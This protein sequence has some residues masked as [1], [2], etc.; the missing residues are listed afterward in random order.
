MRPMPA[1]LAARTRRPSTDHPLRGVADRPMS[2]LVR[3]AAAVVLA[4]AAILS[5]PAPIPVTAAANAAFPDLPAGFA[6]VQLAHG[7]KKPTA[8]V[9]APNG[10]I[11]IAEQFIGIVL[12]R[13]GSVLSTPVLSLTVDQGT[14][15]GILGLALDPNFSTNGYIYV[16]YSTADLHAQVSRFTVTGGGTTASPASEKV[17]V[18]GDELQSAHHGVND[19]H[20]G[21]DGKLWIGMGDN[22]PSISNGHTLNNIYGKILRINLDGTI[23]ADNPFVNVSGA[24]P[25]IYAYGLRNPFRF[26]FLP[27]GKAMT[28]DTGSSYWEELDTI[29]RGGNYGWDYYEGNCFTCGYINPTYAYGH[30]PTDSATSALAAYTGSVFPSTYSDTVF[31]GDY[32]RQDIEAVKFDPTYTTEISQTVFDSAAGTVADLQEGPDGNLYYVGIYEG[33][34]WEI[35]P[36]GPF[37]PTANATSTPTAGQAPLTVQF[38]SAGSSDPT[39]AALGYSW[40]FGDGSAPSTAANPSHTYTTNGTYTADAD[41]GEFGRHRERDDR[42]SEW[43]WRLRLPPSRRRRRAPTTPARPSRSPA[44]RPTRRTARCLPAPT[45]GRSTSTRAASPSPSTSTRCPD[46]S[47]RRRGSRAARSRSPSTRAIRPR[48]STG[49][50]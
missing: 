11:Y 39:G 14:E 26:T 27:N 44:P 3:L 7:L 35:Y 46:R 48:P 10:D 47:S 23:P 6:K 37:A 21:P 28:E 49:S 25:S 22:D 33:S 4:A 1:A 40:D 13:G 29:Q 31:F 20:V 45:T 19:I 8:F 36:T 42:P 16:D 24:V 17:L 2:R 32:V 41:G 15:A 43:G 18:R 30:I 5:G 50:R 12:Y 38:S 34:F 9:F